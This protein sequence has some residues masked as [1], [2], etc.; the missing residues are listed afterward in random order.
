MVSSLRSFYER[1]DDE[2]QR[3][4]QLQHSESDAVIRSAVVGTRGNEFRVGPWHGSET[5]A[6]LTL[7]RSS[8][9]PTTAG[10]LHCLG[11]LRE[12]GIE[13]VLTNAMRS[14]ESVAFLTA[15]FTTV[16]ELD[17]LRRDLSSSSRPHPTATRRARRVDHEAILAVD[18]AAFEEFWRLDQFSLDE[19][20]SATPAVRF[21]YL[22]RDDIT[23]YAI[24]GKAG[25]TGYLQRL[26]VH[27][28]SARQGLGSQL[29]NDAIRWLQRRRATSVL[30]NT[31][32][33][34][35][36]AQQMYRQLGFVPTGERLLVLGYTW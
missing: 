27:P 35:V 22:H 14:G 28:G 30:V 24:C 25:R 7:A 20:L 12:Q 32:V 1:G 21:R 18:A 19:A 36:A 6:Y 16:D 2:V 33:T 23:A 13:R 15:G 8:Q 11:T 17:I 26:A 5:T 9:R 31:Q 29:C 3:A 4:A 34:N 10:V